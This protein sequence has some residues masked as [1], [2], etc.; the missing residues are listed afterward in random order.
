MN[1]GFLLIG[2]NP[3]ITLGT[4]LLL[5]T[6]MISVN[7][8]LDRTT[9]LNRVDRFSLKLSLD[10]GDGGRKTIQERVDELYLR[11]LTA[12]A[13][14]DY[15]LVIQLCERALLLDPGFS[16]AQETLRTARASYDLEQELER[17]RRAN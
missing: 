1:T 3:R 17:L 11:A 13:N 8:T 6:F 10:L 15:L 5:N 12:L 16:P 4:E 9:Q 7:Y 2:G 14:S